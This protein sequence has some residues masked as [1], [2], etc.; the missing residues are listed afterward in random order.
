M[1]NEWNTTFILVIK[2]DRYELIYCHMQMLLSIFLTMLQYI[3]WGYNN[4]KLLFY[5][6]L[7]QDTHMPY[8]FI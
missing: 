2:D 6:A 8:M 1:K 3:E 4:E 5:R 7:N